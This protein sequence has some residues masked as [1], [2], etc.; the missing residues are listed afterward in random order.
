MTRFLERSDDDV[1]KGKEK[2]PIRKGYNG[3]LQRPSRAVVQK[4]FTPRRCIPR[5]ESMAG[6]GS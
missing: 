2:P 1:V 5:S 3:T 6:H 4:D